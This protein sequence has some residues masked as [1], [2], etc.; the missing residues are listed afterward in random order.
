MPRVV[1]DRVRPGE[2]GREGIKIEGSGFVNFENMVH[3][4]VNGVA[5]SRE[6]GNP[7][8]QQLQRPRTIHT[9]QDDESWVDRFTA[10]QLA[11]IDGVLCDDHAVFFEAPRQHFVIRFSQPAIVA[12]MYG[13]MRS[14]FTQ[15]AGEH[16]REAF[17]DEEPQAAFAQGRPPG[18]P[19]KG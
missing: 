12:R 14:R 2:L 13:L 18:R 9:G 11:K 3:D 6:V 16:R 1:R 10:N 5:K 4:H 7:R 8:E 19:R 17:V 15:M